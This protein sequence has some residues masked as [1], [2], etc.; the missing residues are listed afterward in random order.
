MRPFSDDRPESDLH[1]ETKYQ[2]LYEDDWLMAVDKPAPL[3]V[4]SVGRF[5]ERNLLSL[6]KKAG[7]GE[8]AAVVN[9]LDSETSGIVIVA[10]TPEAAGHLGTQFQ[11]RTTH[12]E[13]L[14]IVLGVLDQKHGR[15]DLPLGPQIQWEHKMWGYDPLGKECHTD[16]WVLEEKE[17]YSLVRIVPLTGRT[18]QIRAHFAAI[19]HPVAGDKI[20]IEPKIFDTYVR[21]GWREEMLP[22]VKLSRLA[23]HAACLR[24]RHPEFGDELEFFSEL[25][26]QLQNFWKSL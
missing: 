7:A 21:E 2:I 25:P 8:Q 3:P 19:G 4:H 26:P 15:I 5:Q 20:Y 1:V 9:R 6:L 16:Y 17:E 22:V 10:K 23:L 13:Y 24:V 11:N 12:K 18:H 14:A